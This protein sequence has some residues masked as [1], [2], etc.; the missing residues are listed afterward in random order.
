[1]G[2]DVIEA[3]ASIRVNAIDC[4]ALCTDIGDRAMSAVL[5]APETIVP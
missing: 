3:V 4:A 1:M 2:C 5:N